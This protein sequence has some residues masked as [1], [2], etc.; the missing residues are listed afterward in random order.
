MCTVQFPYFQVW[1]NAIYTG[2]PKECATIDSTAVYAPT[3]A[4]RGNDVTATVSL[5][6]G[7]L[8]SLLVQQSYSLGRVFNS[9]SDP[10]V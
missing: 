5:F 6:A 8:R 1:V 7:S 9:E 10:I 4:D 2:R 3:F